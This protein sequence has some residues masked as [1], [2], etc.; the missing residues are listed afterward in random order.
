MS[1][2]DLWVEGMTCARCVGQVEQALRG[3]DGVRDVK[4]DLEQG[5]AS[6]IGEACEAALVSAL[7]EAGYAASAAVSN[8]EIQ[9]S[10]PMNSICLT[11]AGMTCG[12]CVGRV[13]R[14]LRGWQG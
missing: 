11:V 2:L 4:V 6:V 9:P 10:L 7:N 1:I 13:E 14:A 12:K 3:V 5:R 8:I